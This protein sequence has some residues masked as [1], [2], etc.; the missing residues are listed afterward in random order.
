M[1][2]NREW[3]PCTPSNNMSMCSV[4]IDRYHI[5]DKGNPAHQATIFV[6]NFNYCITEKGNP[7]FQAVLRIRIRMDPE[8]LPGSENNENDLM[9]S[10]K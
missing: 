4:F 6:N 7:G 3:K 8:L 2:D 1:I 5:K 10:S 9:H